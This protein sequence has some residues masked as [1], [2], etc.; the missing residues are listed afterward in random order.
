[1]NGFDRASAA[2]NAPTA[3]ISPIAIFCD[4]ITKQN[5]SKQITPNVEL[6]SRVRLPRLEPGSKPFPA[7]NS[8]VEF[9]IIN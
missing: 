8:E 1:M 6:F 4:M 9:L 3:D 7:R 5:A 2:A